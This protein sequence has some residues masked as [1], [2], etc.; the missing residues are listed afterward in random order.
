MDCFEYIID[1]KFV[2]NYNK[3]NIISY[4]YA[5][6]VC[7]LFEK[8]S[9]VLER[10]LQDLSDENIIYFIKVVANLE[11]EFLNAYT[12]WLI[13]YIINKNEKLD[14]INY[15]SFKYDNIVNINNGYF[16]FDDAGIIYH[17]Q[18]AVLSANVNFLKKY[19]DNL[20]RDMTKYFMCNNY[21][22]MGRVLRRK[23]DE[24]LLNDY[25]HY[26]QLVLENDPSILMYAVRP[27]ENANFLISKNIVIKYLI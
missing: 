17:S 16:T 2:F 13:R 9:E 18:K 1:K 25:P 24:N 22:N 3:D 14:I 15:N 21:F 10:L 11:D 20:N 19:N 6:T 4:F 12:F 27:S 26:Y 8:R 5:F 7:K 23:S